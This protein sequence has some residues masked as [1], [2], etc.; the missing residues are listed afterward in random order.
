MRA[1]I[2]PNDT[3]YL[4]SMK[5]RYS[6]LS[7]WLLSV[8]GTF[9]LAWAIK[10]QTANS[11]DP[12]MDRARLSSIV[13]KSDPGGGDSKLLGGD[14]ASG[15]FAP[16]QAHILKYIESG[17]I[18]EEAMAAAIKDMRRENDPLK[19]RA[20]FSQLLEQLTPENAKAAYLALREGNNRG[21]RGGRGGGGDDESRLLL[22]AWGRIDG[23]GAIAELKAV[24][25]AQRAE[26]EAQALARG[27]TPGEGGNNRGRGGG[28]RGGFG[29]FDIASVL[30]GW[31]TTDVNGA[32]DYVNGLDDE[33]AR[34]MMTG[35]VIR[36]LMVNGVDEAMSFIGSLPA[37]DENR[38][39][40]MWAI[41]EEVLEDGAASAAEWVGN[42][43]DDSLKGGAMQRIAE[44][45]AR[46]NLEDAISWISQHQ[47][48]DYASSAVAQVAE[49]WAEADPQAVIDWAADLP[50]ETQRGVFQEALDE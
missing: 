8:A 4:C 29:G 49:R 18:S 40:H 17:T 10:P 43:S 50:E 14:A 13:G 44:S 47:G 15:E 16:A 48:E 30:S 26:R 6:I 5:I 22:N 20:M 21:G 23:A 19:K 2:A 33:R 9:A 38:S 34:G 37:E 46:E 11:D 24:E 1:L 3:T 27:E 7:L 12:A 41:A 39:R 45:Y 35:S 28:D 25:E 42:L 32:M 36:G 31:A